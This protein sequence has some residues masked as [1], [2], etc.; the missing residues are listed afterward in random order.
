MRQ[1]ILTDLLISYKGIS[2]R[3]FKW[4]LADKPEGYHPTTIYDVIIIILFLCNLSFLLLETSYNIIPKKTPLTCFA[5]SFLS[6][7]ILYTPNSTRTESSS[8]LHERTL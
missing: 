4:V 3:Y 7:L 6:R 2:C 8:W 1:T 5:W